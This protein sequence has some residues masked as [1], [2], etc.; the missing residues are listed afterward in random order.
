VFHCVH[1]T[2]RI[3][4]HDALYKKMCAYIIGN[5]WCTREYLSY[6]TGR[7]VCNRQE[8]AR[9]MAEIAQEELKLSREQEERSRK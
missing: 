1:Y 6:L 4:W 8:E 2:V 5:A 7:C 3:Y 9:L